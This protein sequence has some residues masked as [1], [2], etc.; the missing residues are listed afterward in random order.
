MILI[1]LLHINYVRS[2][3]NNEGDDGEWEWKDGRKLMNVLE[4]KPNEVL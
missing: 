3:G 2:E 1:K 4:I